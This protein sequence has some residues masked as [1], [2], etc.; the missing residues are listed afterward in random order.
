MGRIVIELF[1]VETPNTVNNFAFLAREC[2]YDGTLFHRVVEDF[3][4]QGG[5]PTGTGAGGPGYEFDDEIVPAL[6]FDGPGILGMANRGPDTNGSQFF[7][8]VAGPFPHLDGA[9]TIFGRVIEGQDVADAISEAPANEFS[10]PIDDV[11]VDR[12]RVKETDPT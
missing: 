8:T 4:I 10:R 2:Y 7:I 6:T 11:V 9:F 5:D 1:P 3:V 12:I